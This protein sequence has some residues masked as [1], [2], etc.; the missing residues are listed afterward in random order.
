[1]RELLR[2]NDPVRLSWLQALLADENIEA[3]ILDT[4]TA[5]LEGSAGAILRRLVVIDEDYTRSRRILA[6]AGEMPLSHDGP[7]G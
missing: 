2:S 7:G 5:I 3:V 4:H 6:D 1:M